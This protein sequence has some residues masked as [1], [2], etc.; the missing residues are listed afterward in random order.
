MQRYFL[1]TETEVI[2]RVLSAAKWLLDSNCETLTWEKY[3]LFIVD[4]VHDHVV[5]SHIYKVEVIHQV[6]GVL[7]VFG[8]T[9]YVS[10]D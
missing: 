7:H 4:S 9:K 2:A 1:E 10:A 6:H 8:S 3:L 5:T